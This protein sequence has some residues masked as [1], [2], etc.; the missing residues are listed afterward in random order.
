MRVDKVRI[1]GRFN[2]GTEFKVIEC[3]DTTSEVIA[4]GVRS[5]ED[6]W[7]ILCIPEMIEALKAV[8][9]RVTV[10]PRARILVHDVLEK[11]GVVPYTK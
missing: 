4:Q 7:E 11:L 10:S 8:H 3:L 9:G 1:V 5:W 6:A 2:H